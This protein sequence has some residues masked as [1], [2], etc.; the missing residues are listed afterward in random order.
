MLATDNAGERSS[1]EIIYENETS[2]YLNG[3][4]TKFRKLSKK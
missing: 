2:L 1:Q 4:G 3:S